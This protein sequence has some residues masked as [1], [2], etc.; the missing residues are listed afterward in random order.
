M[1]MKKSR[2]IHWKGT[3]FSSKGG[4]LATVKLKRGRKLN[5]LPKQKD[6]QVLH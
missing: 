3:T 6:L 4:S 2:L 5:T 1:M